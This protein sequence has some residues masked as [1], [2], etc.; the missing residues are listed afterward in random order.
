M[1]ANSK[2][3]RI[4]LFFMITR[5]LTYAQIETQLVPS[6]STADFFGNAVSIHGSQ[7]AIGAYGESEQ[8]EYSG[9]AYIF[10]RSSGIW[11][12]VAR[13]TP[14]DAAEW[15]YFGHSVGMFGDYAIVGALGDDDRGE[16]SGSVYIY[17]Q[18]DG[19][20]SQD[21]KLTASDGEA[22]DDFG[23]S[24][25][26]YGDYAIVGAHRDDTN[27]GAAYI[28]QRMDTGWFEAEKLTAIDG[29]AGDLFGYSV[30]IE[31][32]YAVIGASGS[33]VNGYASGVVYVFKRTDTEWNEIAKLTPEDGAEGDN[34][35]NAVSIS[36]AYTVVGSRGD[37]D[38]GDKSGSVYV[39]EKSLDVWSQLVKLTADDGAAGDSFGTSVSNENN[40]IV[41]GAHK[42]NDN[43]YL[44][45]SAYVFKRD[46]TQWKK[47]AKL[48]STEGSN[49][50]Y[51][52]Q[53][54]S[55]SGGSILIGAM[56]S[57][58][59]RTGLAYVYRQTYEP[60]VTSVRDVANDQGGCV[61]LKWEASYLDLG[62]N[63]SYYSIWR[64]LPDVSSY[65]F[66]SSGG[67][68]ADLSG[69]ASR[70]PT[71][72]G[73]EYAWEWLANQSSHRLQTYSFTA[74]TLYDSMSATDGTHYFFISAHTHDMDVFYD[75]EPV[76]GYSVD[77]LAPAAPVGLS[78]EIQ[79]E[80][81]RLTW[82]MSTEPD[83]AVYVLY[84]N[85]DAYDT[86]RQNNFIDTNVMPGITYAY[87]LRAVDIHENESGFSEEVQAIV[88]GI[89]TEE[90][91]SPGHFYL[92]QNHP[93]PFNSKTQIMYQLPR[94]CITQLVIYNVSGQVIRTLVYAQQ[95]PDTY[96]VHWDGRDDHDRQVTS[97]IYI[98][99]LKA[100]EF[101]RT[102]KMLYNQ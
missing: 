4:G 14:G 95:E 55:I 82:E 97:G 12:E 70:P 77:N 40:Y 16:G 66:S 33:N 13:L 6:G 75:S 98:Y 34:F 27:K 18:T 58:Y 65:K 62:R 53:S 57:Q 61:T 24:V 11:N 59:H 101:V 56:A 10:K 1:N 91:L 15:D 63:V 35:G 9:A 88:V 29:A 74:S 52:G 7:I 93:N 32:D 44:S 71:L 42:D 86:I 28:F 38:C 85:N 99:H 31:G 39:F 26:L 3:F 50:D 100:G 54:V 83:L 21:A 81:I 8:G 68:H 17:K 76:S 94:P 73:T 72:N 49:Y 51:Y 22:G 45:G 67:T 60:V 78:A 90:R 25:S 46:G 89:E 64:A 20:W 30:C 87:K 19:G 47:E 36:G 84:R 41:V 23:Y 48:T 92:S 69:S 43:G 2:V 96:R 5:C 79:D 37:D 102:R 80:A